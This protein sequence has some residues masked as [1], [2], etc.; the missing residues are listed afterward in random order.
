[1][2]NSPT[3]SETI[4]VGSFE[5]RLCY[6]GRDFEL[7]YV[8]KPIGNRRRVNSSL[9]FYGDDDDLLVDDLHLTTNVFA[10]T[11]NIMP[12]MAR[13][14]AE[15]QPPKFTLIAN[16]SRKAKPY[17]RFAKRLHR[18]L[19]HL[20]DIEFTPNGAIFYYDKKPKHQRNNLPLPQ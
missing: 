3:F 5:Y 4:T 17:Q 13:R 6:N 20:Y 15:K 10:L 19:N 16:T 11:V 1:M 12:V 7:A 2:T 18:H 9:V 8:N 14:M